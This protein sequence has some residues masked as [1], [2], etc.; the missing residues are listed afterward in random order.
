M[1]NEDRIDYLEQERTKIW[2]R[3][4]YIENLVAK[5]TSDYEEDAKASAKQAAAFK[6]SSE[7][8]SII[9]NDFVTETTT[10]L[11][12]IRENYDTIEKLY[13]DI[14]KDSED[15]KTNG[16]LIKEIHE[17]I[18]AKSKLIETQIL[19]IEKIFTNKPIIDKKLLDLDEV[20]KKGDDY[21]SKLSGLFKSISERKKEI[22]ELYYQIIGSVDKDENGKEIKIDGLKDELEESYDSV[23]LKIS[24]TEKE[25]TIYKDEITG[26]Y[27]NFVENKKL[28]FAELTT[29]WKEEYEKVLTVA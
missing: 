6:N 23:K 18:E 12:I 27:T 10:K 21:D 13:L 20:F 28:E 25:I 19:E 8:S 2:E 5:K 15:S 4:T 9:I 16:D 14:K 24:E 1:N 11:E 22:D 26:N 29:T 7:S 17:N 3:L